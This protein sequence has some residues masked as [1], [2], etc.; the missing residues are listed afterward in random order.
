MIL[1]SFVFIKK[2]TVLFKIWRV[3]LILKDCHA[4]WQLRIEMGWQFQF[5][6]YILQIFKKCVFFEDAQLILVPYL[7]ISYSF[8]FEK[9]ASKFQ[10]ILQQSLHYLRPFLVKQQP[11]NIFPFVLTTKQVISCLR[12]V[13]KIARNVVKL[14]FDIAS[15]QAIFCRRFHIHTN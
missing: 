8:N 4:L 10:S 7:A 1:I 9:N 12:F 13:K 5:L 15:E 11:L 14:A 3:W 6:S 2:I